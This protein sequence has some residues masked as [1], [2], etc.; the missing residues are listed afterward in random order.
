MR[1]SHLVRAAVAAA[2]VLLAPAAGPAQITPGQIDTFTDGTT[3]NWLDG[4]FS[5]NPPVVITGGGPGGPTDNY[6]QDSAGGGIG[7]GSRL[8]MFN[9]V[10]W[11]GDYNAAG[12][13]VITMSLRAPAT[14]TQD[15]MIR[16]AFKVD[17]GQF[18]P[19]YVS[20]A[21][22]VLD[23]D[24]AWH[25]ATFTL[26]AAQ[27]TAV[28]APPPF[29]EFMNGPGEMRILH[30]AGPALN[31]DPINAILG[32]DN[33]QAVP[34]PAGLLAAAGAAAGLAWLSRRRVGRKR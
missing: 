11:L 14:N 6:L 1:L 33:I 15:L 24:G 34:E 25:D 10:Q 8:I 20:T 18:S 26:S 3:M 29:A 7:A 31:G 27:M 19:G 23:N 2:V 17:P 28:G 9:R 22:F 5:P 16:I 12:V 30:A 32:V 4:A 21:P 13:N